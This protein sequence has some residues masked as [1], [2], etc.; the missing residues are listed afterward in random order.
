MIRLL[1]VLFALARPVSAEPMR[2][3]SGEH[4]EFTRL[5]V[6]LPAAL[7]WT[8]GRTPKGYAFAVAGLKNPDYDLSGV[9]QKISRNRI[10]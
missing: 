5:V 8:V 2:V 6:E 1:L 10:A 7:D 3:Y 4:G 9:L